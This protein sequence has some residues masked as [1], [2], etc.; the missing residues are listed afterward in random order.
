[1]ERDDA[2]GMASPDFLDFLDASPPRT[3]QASVADDDDDA[4]A[5]AQQR[6]RKRQKRELD[7]LQ[8]QVAELSSH[9]AVLKNIRGLEV[10]HSSYWEKKARMQKLGRQQATSENARL[11]RAIEEQLKVAE[12]LNQLLVKRP[13]LVAFPTMDMVD[14]KLRRL[15][16]DPAA[17]AIAYHAFM[18][19]VYE[20]V[21]T[22]LLRTGILDAPD[23]LRSIDLSTTDDVMTVDVRG[24]KAL[25]CHFLSAALRFWSLWNDASNHILE[26]TIRVKVLEAFGDD[27][28]YIEQTESLGDAMPYLRRLGALKRY[29]EEDRVVFVFRTVLDDEKYPPVDGLYIGND[30]IVLILERASDNMAVRRVC[31]SGELPIQAPPN[32]PLASNPQH[33]IC[34]FIL[35]EVKR[36]FETLESLFGD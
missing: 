28:V 1:M 11:K 9:L 18:N 29:V 31:M 33:L 6:F 5:T 4:N 23:G 36:T 7:F 13:K 32:G 27:G 34:D 3:A 15:P 22:I 24:V 21:D 20:R 14:W 2:W 25:P 12:I 19:D 8:S 35:R 26:G 10:S 30:T 16:R 17:R